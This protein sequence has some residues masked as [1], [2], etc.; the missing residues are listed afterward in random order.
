VV[1][2][3]GGDEFAVV[4]PATEED[5]ERLLERLACAVSERNRH[6]RRPYLIRYS[7][8]RATC[9]PALCHGFD[10]LVAEADA[11]MY[12]AKQGKGQRPARIAP[13]SLLVLDRA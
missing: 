11:R 12:A 10:S 7:V 3:I 6:G 9:D 5:L 1:A 13:D 4:T 8:G 2:R